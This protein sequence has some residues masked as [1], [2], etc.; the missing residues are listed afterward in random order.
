MKTVE[1]DSLN[2][3][4]SKLGFGCAS[5]MGR[6]GKKK[7]LYAMQMAYELGVRHFDIARSYGYGEA[8]D[9]LGRFV[10]Q[11]RDKL[12][13]TTKFGINPPKNQKILSVV[14]PIAR[15]VFEKFPALRSKISHKTDRILPTGLFSKDN[16]KKSLNDS[17]RALKTDYVD[18]FMLHDCYSKDIF[19]DE[20]LTLLELFIQE[21]KIRAWGVATDLR[22]IEK[23]LPIF[24]V[25]PKIIQYEN[26]V[27]NS[28]EVSNIDL[29]NMNSILHSPF[30][31]LEGNSTI[32]QLC[33]SSP[34]I[35][36]GK[37]E[38]LEISHQK[39]SRYI[40][41]GAISLS[42]NSVVLCSMFSKNHISQNIEAVNNPDLTSAQCH[43]FINICNVNKKLVNFK[44]MEE[45]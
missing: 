23:L 3:S 21:G 13:I 26:N 15:V 18:F 9:V 33:N 19:S 12:T 35:E 45:D 28:K 16:V 27:W 24:E 37:K 31:G 2:I 38:N 43:E 11:K 22:T 25:K 10:K 32:D 34:I 42:N 39:L 6:V 4:T 7:S 30:G 5:V 40:L 29:S 36:W 1:W 8:E 44:L 17:L 41:E 20:L 14:K